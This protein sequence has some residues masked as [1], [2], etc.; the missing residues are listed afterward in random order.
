MIKKILLMTLGLSV[1]IWADLSH[2]EKRG[3]QDMKTHYTI[4][5]E[6]PEISIGTDSELL[7]HETTEIPTGDRDDELVPMEHI[8]DRP[9]EDAK[10]VI[11]KSNKRVEEKVKI[12]KITEKE[13]L[14]EKMKSKKPEKS[15]MTQIKSENESEIERI[16]REL[17]IK[18]PSQ[19]ELKLQKIK[20]QLDIKEPSVQT[21]RIDSIREELNIGYRTPKNE[22]RLDRRVEDVKEG[23]DALSVDN[24][25]SSI[26]STIGMGGKKKDTGFSITNSISDF[27][28]T[29]GID[30]G[31][32]SFFGSSSKKKE[33]GVLDSVL[34]FGI[35][36]DIRDT[37]TSM[38]KGAKY[39][40]QSAEMM[41]GMMYNSSKMYNTMFGVFDDSP[42]NLFE[43]EEEASMFDVF[44]HGNA[45][46][47]MFN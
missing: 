24:A 47:D 5:D 9:D 13:R 43:E 32:P 31:I 16:R 37:G 27:G 34:G 38:Y 20:A 33:S 45:V 4:Q 7:P 17:D 30:I 22:S 15:Q 23:L 19:K 39:S 6:T 41:S 11:K 28:D 44:E 12:P 14:P 29:I 8:F 1:F 3:L 26:K 36:G 2:D 35:L 42:F 21:L 18:G 10:A 25:L 46:M 40:G